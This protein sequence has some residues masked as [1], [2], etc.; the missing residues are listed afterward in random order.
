L[1]LRNKS[2]RLCDGSTAGP[3]A[4]GGM[5]FWGLRLIRR[6]SLRRL[7]V[8]RLAIAIPSFQR[9]LVFRLIL[10]GGAR[11]RR[12]FTLLA[13]LECRALRAILATCRVKRLGIRDCQQPRL[14]S[15]ELGSR[16]RVFV[17]IG[18]SR[19]QIVNLEDAVERLRMSA[20]QFRES[21]R[22]VLFFLLEL[23]KKADKV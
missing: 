4:Y 17:A 18:E 9:R 20:K 11:L 3:S 22:L 7:G 19:Q 23:L 13:P 16:N 5:M 15:I 8:S 14:H 21:A 10:A 1:E 6:L 2:G 12:V